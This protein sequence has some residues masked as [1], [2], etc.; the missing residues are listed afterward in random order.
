MDSK[1]V[2]N[3]YLIKEK[4]FGYFILNFLYNKASSSYESKLLK[5]AWSIEVEAS[6]Y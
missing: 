5:S 4:P 1:Q 3:D 6:M 2:F